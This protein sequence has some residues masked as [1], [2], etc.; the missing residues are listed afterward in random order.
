MQVLRAA[1][2]EGMS[3]EDVLEAMAAMETMARYAALYALWVDC[4]VEVAWDS[5]AKQLAWGLVSDD[6]E[7]SR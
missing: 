4:E 6:E 2:S 3:E 1:G 7:E 5:E